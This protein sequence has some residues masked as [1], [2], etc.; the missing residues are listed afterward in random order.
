MA[1]SPDHPIPVRSFSCTCTFPPSGVSLAVRLMFANR[2]CALKEKWEQ[3]EALKKTLLVLLA[4]F[5]FVFVLWALNGKSGELVRVLQEEILAV[6]ARHLNIEREMV[7]IKL[8]RG[9]TISR[10]M[11]RC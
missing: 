9:A 5:F 3:R 1:R 2:R 11:F 10:S 6:V 7:Q 8:D 4:L